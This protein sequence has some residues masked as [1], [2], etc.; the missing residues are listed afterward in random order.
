[1]GTYLNTGLLFNKHYFNAID[2][3]NIES[4]VNENNLRAKNKDLY[5]TK[6]ENSSTKIGTHKI[7]LKTTYPGLFSGSGYSHESGLKGELKLGFYFDYT[8]GLPILS[9]SS[10]KGVLR[11]AFENAN[12]D[13]VAEQIFSITNKEL[14][15]WK[16]DRLKSSI[17][18]G[19]KNQS[20]YDR[21]IFF[22]AFPIGNISSGKFLVDDYITPHLDE[23]LKNPTPIKFLKIQP[24]VRIQFNFNLSD[25]GGLTAEEKKEL[26]ERILLDLGIGSKSNVGYGQFSDK[27][28]DEADNTSKEKVLSLNPGKTLDNIAVGDELNAK[29]YSLSGGIFF[30][31]GIDDIKFKSRL[32]GVSP[33]LFKINDII[34]IRVEQI[35]KQM[36]FSLIP[37]KPLD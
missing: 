25:S 8:T 23:P 32:L 36:T 6:L 4:S 17:F 15:L 33:K 27:T 11:S 18:D 9:G 1:M 26:F 24:N 16:V 3:T 30:D 20:I 21:D 31:L 2:F 14:D 29:I 5:S 19:D 34:K 28:L 22:D 13:Y 35:G 7:L 10:V 37:A 12:G